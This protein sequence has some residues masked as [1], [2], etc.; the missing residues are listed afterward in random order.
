MLD[1]LHSIGASLFIILQLDPLER[2]V[3]ALEE[4]TN[5]VSSGRSGS[6]E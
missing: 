1:V 2:D 3:T 6:N 4:I 5:R